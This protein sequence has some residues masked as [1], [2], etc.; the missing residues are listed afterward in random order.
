[1]SKTLTLELPD[2]VY[3]AVHKAAE[4]A[5]TTPADW[6][7]ANVGEHVRPRDDRL[8]NLFGTVSLGHPTGIDNESIDTDLAK[9]YGSSHEDKSS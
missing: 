3:E 6:I 4:V 1:M 2:D 9:E 7:A 5:G 8:R